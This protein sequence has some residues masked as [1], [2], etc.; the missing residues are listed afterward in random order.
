MC[1]PQKGRI[2]KYTLYPSAEYRQT[3]LIEQG[4]EIPRSIEVDVPLPDLTPASRRVLAG[5]ESL[6]PT[7]RVHTQ[8]FRSLPY[9]HTYYYVELI[10]TTP[11]EW[12]NLCTTYTEAVSQAH[13]AWQSGAEADIQHA[14]ATLE[15]L[16]GDVTL[17]EDS[18]WRGRVPY[19]ADNAKGIEG[20]ER[21]SMLR[22]QV[23]AQGAAVEVAREERHRAAQAQKDREAQALKDAKQAEKQAWIM[24]HGS[25]HLQRATTAGYPCTRCYVQERAAVE[26]PGYV[27]DFEKTSE[28]KNRS[29]PSETAL[30]EAE[31]S[32]GTVVWL[33]QRA[34]SSIEDMD[35]ADSEEPCEAV[36][37]EEYLGAYTLVHTI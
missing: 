12:E 19:I 4:I 17:G 16:V 9:Q 21:Y 37:V 25:P 23:N 28:W 1:G 8:R 5:G 7:S 34:S 11:T 22:E 24:A 14:L 31:R 6:T 30:D 33:T 13:A 26:H 35:A 32:K 20:Y 10:P 36:V 27:V 3:Q 2:V 15:C 29:C 18:H